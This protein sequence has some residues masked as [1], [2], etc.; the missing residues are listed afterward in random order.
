[1]QRSFV[2]IKTQTRAG[3]VSNVLSAFGMSITSVGAKKTFID[4][5]DKWQLL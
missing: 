5:S 2:W 3:G 1:M 4:L